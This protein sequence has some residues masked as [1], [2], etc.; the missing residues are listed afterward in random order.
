MSDLQRTAEDVFLHDIQRLSLPYGF[1][2]L[3]L[4]L[5]GQFDQRFALD[6]VLGMRHAHVRP[7][8]QGVRMNLTQ[9]DI[10]AVFCLA[11]FRYL[12][13]LTR[14]GR[15]N[16]GHALTWFAAEIDAQV[17]NLLRKQQK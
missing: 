7:P 6:F 9:H 2:D 15:R 12:I 16:T 8:C 5:L 4:Q 14:K 13:Q 17:L 10:E 11:H 3:C 1:S